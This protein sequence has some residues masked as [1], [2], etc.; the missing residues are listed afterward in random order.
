[1]K[2]C[3]V[4]H[5][6]SDDNAK[7]CQECGHPFNFE[8]AEDHTN[9]EGS[10]DLSKEAVQEV[11]NE[12]QSDS[13]EPAYH[14]EPIATFENTED[15]SVQ[16]ETQTD[17]SEPVQDL[18]ERWYY[19]E[20]GKSK[21]PFSRSQFLDLIV[22]GTVT[23]RTYVWTKGMDEWTYLKNTAL[24]GRDNN[25]ETAPAQ[26]EAPVFE[27]NT[28]SE[29]GSYIQPQSVLRNEEAEDQRWFYVVKNRTVG[30][31]STEVMIRN[32]HQG[33][34]DG[35][36]Y[37]W[38]EG[39]DDWKHLADTPFAQY[40]P[41]DSSRSYSTT[42]ESFDDRGAYS[43]NNYTSS[44]VE[45]VVPTRNIML[46][47]LLSIVTC[48]IFE[49]VWFYLIAADI[50]K[51]CIARGRRPLTDPILVLVYSFL[52]CGIYSIYYFWKAGNT[53]YELNDGRQPSVGVIAAILGLILQPAAL[54]II[55]D[56]INGMAEND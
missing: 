9:I 48:G 53:L 14:N 10:A 44:N 25:Q 47:L 50:N 15:Q 12:V 4:C 38:R 36:T 45:G 1:M 42:G 2:K 33:I 24:Y 34:I 30:P 41:D 29:S 37:V 22:D 55:Q 43:H 26:P 21:G 52:T 6:E 51:L 3:P 39:Y 27:Q 49:L 32:I 5:T 11:S 56:Q 35:S 19:V 16:A 7:F 40:L 46:Y 54:A 31:F 28:V 18:G 8:A 17:P 20:S 13:S 23:P